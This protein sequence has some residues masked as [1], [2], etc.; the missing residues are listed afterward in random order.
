VSKINEL[1]RKAT[2]A[3]RKRD[4]KSAVKL[5]EKVCEIDSANAS[6]RNE[7][8]DIYLKMGDV[9]E[10]L[11][12]FA[13]AAE[14][15]RSVSLHNNAVAVLKKILRHDKNHL[16]ATWGLGEVR[17]SQGLDM[18]AQQ[19]F[20]EFLGMA[21][22]VDG[23]N[24]QRFTN[25]CVLLVEKYSDD[26]QM[27]SRVAEVFEDWKLSDDHAR[28]IMQKA[29]LAHGEGQGELVDKYIEKA[30][31]I[32]PDLDTLDDYV[33]LMLLRNGGG[34]DGRPS[35]AADPP[36]SNFIEIDG[37][38][39]SSNEGTSPRSD[40]IELDAAADD[41]DM[42]E[43][44][45]GF[46]FDSG[47][48]GEFDLGLGADGE[49]VATSAPRPAAPSTPDPD[50]ASRRVDLSGLDAEMFAELS[51]S[52][53][54]EFSAAGEPPQTEAQQ[55]TADSAS[56]LDELLSEDS[57]YDRASGDDRQLESIE[58]HLGDQIAAQVAAD[59]YAGQYDVGLVYM[60]MGLYVQAAM[61]F[62][63]ASCGPEHRLRALEMQGSCL[64]RAGR[65]GEALAAFQDG[66][67]TKGQPER[68]FLGLLYEVGICY[69][70][71]GK[72]EIARKAFERTAAIDPAFRDVSERL[73]RIVTPAG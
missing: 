36:G 58:T 7:L 3:A 34:A 56:L 21:G 39:E 67:N 32:Y 22:L 71:M 52:A 73:Q 35:K 55:M 41:A 15:Y 16:D 9:H 38:S 28:V 57:G 20:I 25:R 65:N 2:E 5:Y 27:L 66:L 72:P 44:D 59:D 37:P 69:E 46:D 64:R 12:A 26:L 50:D 70:A 14:L 18:E 19:H 24:R 8:G 10:A 54:G 23:V 68:H 63:R 40:Y 45:L 6:F 13:R 29:R 60:E 61:A 53:H 31:A 4:W 1:R 42:E 51:K 62:G 47:A 11:D 17:E 30:R 43:I 48:A 49:E 33:E